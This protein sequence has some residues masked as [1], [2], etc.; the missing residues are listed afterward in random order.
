MDQVS[1]PPCILCRSSTPPPQCVE[2]HHQHRN[3]EQ[4]R[5]NLGAIGWEL[6]P[7]QV[8]AVIDAASVVTPAYL[9]W[10]QRLAERN[11]PPV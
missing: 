10:H 11:P 7:E 4:L 8:V 9:T 3:E 1:D 6:T 2:R 5:Q